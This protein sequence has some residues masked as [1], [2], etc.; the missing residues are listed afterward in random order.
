VN[1]PARRCAAATV[2]L[3]AAFAVAAASASAA[4][5]AGS[6]VFDP[7]PSGPPF[8]NPTRLPLISIAV[9]Y[10]DQAG[11]VTVS[12][13]GGDPSYAPAGRGFKESS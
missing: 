2:A 5:R 6:L 13:S 7:N 10:D 3:L 11:S 8:G 12:Q 9:S 1:S 4:V